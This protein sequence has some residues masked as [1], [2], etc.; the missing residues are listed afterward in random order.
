MS[1]EY[2]VQVRVI[3]DHDGIVEVDDDLTVKDLREWIKDTWYEL[4]ADDFTSSGYSVEEPVIKEYRTLTCPICHGEGCRNC[5]RGQVRVAVDV[6]ED[7][8]E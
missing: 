5:Y 7:G 8:A 2:Y 4:W 1:K 6:Q 3:S